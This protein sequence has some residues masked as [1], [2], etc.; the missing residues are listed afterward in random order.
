M[1]TRDE[2]FD[3][4]EEYAKIKFS[5]VFGS[6]SDPARIYIEPIYPDMV[7]VCAHCG[8][9]H[10]SSVLKCLYCGSTEGEVIR[11]KR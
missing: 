5:W 11:A 6:L 7:W 2:L 4:I 3:A 1:A 9:V 8:S 10:N